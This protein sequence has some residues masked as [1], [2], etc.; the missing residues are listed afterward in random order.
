[1]CTTVIESIG[2]NFGLNLCL[3]SSSYFLQDVGG[4]FW[5]KVINHS[6][7]SISLQRS[8]NL[9]SDKSSPFLHSWPYVGLKSL[10]PKK[11][12]LAKQQNR[13]LFPK[14][15]GGE[16]ASSAIIPGIFITFCSALFHAN[17]CSGCTWL[18][19]ADENTAILF[20]FQVRA[21]INDNCPKTSAFVV[22]PAS[23]F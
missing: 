18:L 5:N 13:R 7:Q 22:F 8:Y 4:F 21:K 12:L 19:Y 15:T 6:K 23:V 2:W 10:R 11:I 16:T 17:C 3:R 1:V 20:Y 14:T 9:R